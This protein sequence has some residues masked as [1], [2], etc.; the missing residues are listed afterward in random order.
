MFSSDM[1][2]SIL[3]LA[4]P[5]IATNITV[6]LLGLCD[7]SIS[8]HLGSGLYLAAIA[9][10]TMAVNSVFWILG[11][12]RMGTT[13]LTAQAYGAGD[14]PLQR[15]LFTRASL[16]A[17]AAGILLILLHSPLC[18]L[19]MSL[20]APEEGVKALASQYFSTVIF[21]APAMLC[22]MV[23]SG[24]LLG[25]QTSVQPMIIA[26][27][28]NALNILL[29]L[30]FAFGFGMGFAG[31]AL[32]T[33]A[34]QWT[35]LFIALFLV[36]RFAGRRLPLAPLREALKKGGWGRFAGV[37]LYI[38]LRSFCIIAVTMAVTALGARLGTA[39]LAANVV[40]MQFFH[41]FSYFM[42]GFAFAGEALA[43]KATGRRDKALLGNT[44][45]HLS[46]WGIGVTALFILIYATWGL[47]LSSFITDDPATLA[48]IGELDSWLW[49]PALC[50]AAAFI[51]DGIF[52]GLT[53][54]R[55]MLVSTLL[56]LAGFAVTM[57]LMP[58]AGNDGLWTA[59][60]I[61]LALRG[62]WLA[63]RYPRAARNASYF[64]RQATH[65]RE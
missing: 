51:L 36:W 37:N 42:D 19:I 28:T 60:S 12:L 54:T 53:A 7:T 61:Y 48:L 2:K 32:G 10:G 21:G 39:V 34:A 5:S 49:I 15:L 29:S 40:I 4:L 41:I 16:L 8:G 46:L 44:V 14:P 56:G 22:T 3:R 11:F 64:R 55:S 65:K 18:A 20:I 59:F 63:L 45:A 26:I 47:T 58:S 35:G 33:L 23:A 6:P 25:M 31:T 27:S 43:G 52:I 30:L 38:F 50:G 13:G 24:W 17:L 57:K 1:N 9:V 62:L